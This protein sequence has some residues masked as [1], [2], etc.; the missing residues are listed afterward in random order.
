V[1]YP[2]LTFTLHRLSPIEFVATASGLFISSGDTTVRPQDRETWPPQT[3]Q[4]PRGWKTAVEIEQLVELGLAVP[5]SNSVSIPYK[6]F[7][8]I[9][10]IENGLISAWAVP[11]PFLLKIDRRS[12]IGRPDFVYKYS[13][14]AAGN[15]IS[16]ERLGY[17][18]RRESDERVFRL[19]QQTYAVVEAMDNFNSLPPE[20][21][22]AQESW[23]T[24]AKVKMCAS[25]VGADLDA[26]LRANDVILP[27]TIGL[28]I[29]EDEEGRLTFFPRCSE[30]ADDD[31]RNV[32]QRNLEAQGLYSLDRPGLG[33]VRVVLSDDSK[34]YFA[35]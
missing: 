31:F 10:S 2:Q 5:E 8:E 23:S 20:G 15:P 34:K 21:K 9:E 35:G 6:N 32:F 13:F 19:D 11:N 26:T 29:F 28:D 14:I 27:S 7:D 33:R 16:F 12:D 17:Y 1:G 24:L 18:I 22:T 4:A 3:L 25:G 30:L